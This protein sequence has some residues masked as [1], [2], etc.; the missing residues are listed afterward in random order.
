MRDMDVKERVLAGALGG[1]GGTFVLSG[2]RWALASMGA[3]F[4]SSASWT[5]S[6]PAPGKP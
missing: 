6:P 2:L 5:A 3:V 4:S 1:F